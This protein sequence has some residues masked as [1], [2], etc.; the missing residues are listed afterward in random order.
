[1]ENSKES[2]SRNHWKRYVVLLAL[3]WTVIIAVSLVWNL[4]E[5]RRWVLEVAH[6]QANMAYD[7][8]IIYRRW[9][10][11]HGGVYVEV[12]GDVRPNPFLKNVPERD[13]KTIS[14]KILTLINPAL[15]MREVYELTEIEH[16]I[17]EHLVSLD[18][19]N[20]SNL[21][22]DWEA[23]A[24][25]DFER[26]ANSVSKVEEVD[27]MERLRFVRPLKTE[28]SCL[29]CHSKQG[30]M[31]GDIQGAISIMLPM[32]PLWATARRS[33][34]MLVTAHVLLWL[35]GGVGIVMAATRLRQSEE[36]TGAALAEKEVLLKEIHHRVKN[37]LQIMS[38]LLQIQSSAIKG[39]KAPPLKDVLDNFR[40]RIM[41]MAEIH[42]LLHKSKDI[43]RVSLHECAD[44]VGTDLIKVYGMDSRVTL[45][46]E[47]N[48]DLGL[49]LAT[50]CSLI[51]NEFVR[52][53]LK[54]AFED[55]SAGKIRVELSED[56]LGTVRISVADDGVGIAEGIDWKNPVSI[57]L[58]LVNG[59]VIQLG[60]TL[61][62]DRSTGTK[63]TVE[64]MKKWR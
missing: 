30:Y 19:L 11:D 47:G 61:T 64:F 18:P 26:G 25:R 23:E 5:V 49:D 2:A 32:K 4:F 46:V 53:S 55:E 56:E 34:S 12:T 39:G 13:L 44:T 57:G 17:S 37:N 54:H 40:D 29:R 52:N 21:P 62:L 1:M 15:M 8:N 10:T 9:N 20:P 58:D 14:G 22:D 50:P 7:K 42:E 45:E 16:G 31:E 59:L 48:V 33:A 43:A 28:K 51:I 3:V 24:L 38:G 41:S 35:L 60:G 36:E 63:F 27:G 6:T